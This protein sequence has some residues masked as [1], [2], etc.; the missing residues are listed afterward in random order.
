MRGAHER[1]RLLA[2]GSREVAVPLLTL[3]ADI[4]AIENVRARVSDAFVTNGAEVRDGN[5]LDRRLLQ[6][7]VADGGVRGF[8]EAF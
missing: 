8:G 4:D 3:R 6:E 5:A 2:L 7:K 1:N